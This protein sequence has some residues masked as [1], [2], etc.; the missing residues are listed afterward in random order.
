MR[1]THHRAKES[2]YQSRYAAISSRRLMLLAII[3][4]ARPNCMMIRAKSTMFLL[5]APVKGSWL[6]T[7][8][9]VVADA[10]SR[11]SAVVVVVL[12]GAS[13]VVVVAS[14]LVDVVLTGA[15]LVVVVAGASVVDVVAGTVVVGAS[16]VDG[17][18]T[19]TEVVVVGA[20]VVVVV[21]AS[22][23]VVVGAGER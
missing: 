3:T 12:A 7:V 4:H 8:G 18:T 22:V 15:S 9:T 1:A 20:A 2:E 13:L 19:I 16:V 5:S 17:V 14:A 10:A 6:S 11:R 21:G 23:V